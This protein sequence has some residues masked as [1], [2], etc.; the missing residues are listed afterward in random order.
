MSQTQ[1]PISAG[2][3][4]I[5]YAAVIK[6][7]PWLV[8]RNQNCILS[9][10][11]D[12]LLCGLFMSHYLNW[13][14]R[15]FYD[16]KILLLE[17]GQM[18]KDC[19][20]LDMEIF[21]QE[22]RSVGQHMVLFNRD[23]LPKNWENFDNCFS[24]NNIRA[25][26][27]KHNFPQKYP[28]ATIHLLLGTVGSVQKIPIVKEAVCP[29]LYTDG[30]FKN[31]FNYPENCISWLKFLQGENAANP[32]HAIFFNDHY[33]ISS[34]MRALNELFSE[35]RLIAD[36]KRGGDKIR[37]S[38]SKGQ[39]IH[40]DK[41]TGSI[42]PKTVEQ[43]KEFLALLADKTGWQYKDADWSWKKLAHFIFKKN[44]IKPSQGRYDELM[45]KN[46]LSLAMTSSIGIE[47]SFDSQNIF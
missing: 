13:K 18:P 47:H 44:T 40:F 38:N 15:G 5:D 34:L 42:E 3:D 31:L 46:P 17:K 26:D 35:L 6:K 30:T 14:I 39:I 16:G 45:A 2:G 41:K 12:G 36:G 1:K 29:L 20:F 23:R 22:I 4:I 10:D 8:R 37:I 24:A 25:Y 33:S 11:S 28:L 43:A 19:I 7:Y 27:A 32:L 21:R 9:P